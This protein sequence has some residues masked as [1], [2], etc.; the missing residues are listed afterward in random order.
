MNVQV[1]NDNESGSGAGRSLAISTVGRRIIARIKGQY[2]K[3]GAS[4]TVK[5]LPAVYRKTVNALENTVGPGGLSGSGEGTR[6]WRIGF[7]VVVA[8]V[9]GMI[10]WSVWAPIESAAVAR[11]QVVLE[12]RR[13]AIQHLEGGIISQIFVADGMQVNAGAPLIEIKATDAKADLDVLDSQVADLQARRNRILQELSASPRSAISTV[14]VASTD[15]SPPPEEAAVAPSTEIVGEALA[16]RQPPVLALLDPQP[17]VAPDPLSVN[18]ASAPDAR[19]RMQRDLFFAR[20]AT[21]DAQRESLAQ[22]VLQQVARI[23]GLEARIAGVTSRLEALQEE[24]RTA[25]D[26]LKHGAET[27]SNVRAIRIQIAEAE[28]EIGETAALISEARSLQLE[29]EATLGQFDLAAREESYTTL[30]DLDAEIEALLKRRNA[31]QDVVE[32]S[33]IRAPMSGTVIALQSHTIGGV[34][35]PGSKLMEIVPNSGAY[36]IEAR[37][38]V[39]DIDGIREGQVARV[40][41]TALNSRVTP[42]ISA[43]VRHVSADA[44]LDP[45]AGGAYYVVRVEL[46]AGNELAGALRGQNLVPGMPAEVYIRTGSRP[47][48]SWLLKPLTDA[49]AGSLREA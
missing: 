8:L 1:E 10:V 38:R 29:G 41:L 2:K 22:R 11:G 43:V 6:Y 7:G 19:A 21:R 26:L 23:E 31:A 42:E 25:E 49:L 3:I 30:A 44:I 28:A 9:G 39:E 13:Q 12:N 17:S 48:L 14:K 34:T 15:N 46:P 32:R 4:E 24:A 5:N 27:K 20:R 18:D 40:R 16:L 37:A 33:I 47:A 36:F 35:A 45:A